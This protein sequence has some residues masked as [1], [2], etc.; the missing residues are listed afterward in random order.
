MEGIFMSNILIVSGHND[1][2]HSRANKIILENLKNDFPNAEF[3]SLIELYP[4]YK[5]NIEA[6]QAKLVKA[7]IIVLQFPLFWFSCPSIM[8]KWFEDVL[9]H[10]FAYGTTGKALD[11]KKIL[12]SFTL[13]A[14][15]EK[16]HHGEFE[17]FEIEEFMPQFHQLANLCS[18]E[19]CGYICSGGYV[20]TAEQE[21]KVEIANKHSQDLINKIK[22][23]M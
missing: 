12:V 7:D 6:E 4:D 20:F 13:G 16:Y 22:T 14:P 15:E 19:W 2:Q 9:L 21:K 17:N 8:R 5:F 10:G 18:M 3:D 11:G 1:I 23:L